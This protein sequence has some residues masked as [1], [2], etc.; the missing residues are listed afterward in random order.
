MSAAGFGGH[1]L[2]LSGERPP[3]D[4]VADFAEVSLVRGE[5]VLRAA[6]HYITT[7]T[8]YLALA[9]Y[10]ADLCRAFHPKPVWYRLTDFES[11]EIG[12]LA[13]ADAVLDEENPILGPRGTRRALMFPAAFVREVSC[14]V[15]VRSTW[16]NLR[17]LP[18]YVGA[19]S[20]LEQLMAVLDRA[21]LPAPDGCMVETPAA[22]RGARRLAE[23]GVG[24]AVIGLN[25]LASLFLGAH[26]GHAHHA[27]DHELLH[28]E[29]A[30]FVGRYAGEVVVA[31]AVD[32]EHGA[33]L[34]AIG[35]A[36]VA[37]HYR[38]VPLWFPMR[39]A[40]LPDL[41]VV[42]WVRRRTAEL[43]TVRQEGFTHG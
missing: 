14:V 35:A 40:N 34:R 21:G 25:D 32:A 42:P 13:G 30:D 6:G 7:P 26:R 10:L 18:S 5:Y 28:D 9:G 39:Y 15:E 4:V 33:R 20:E 22:L 43:L 17:Y 41:G 23:L 38:D 36:L 12:T 19:V 37:V 27:R 29:I 1:G 24:R 2:I 8:G 11:R 16:P 31:N 3:A